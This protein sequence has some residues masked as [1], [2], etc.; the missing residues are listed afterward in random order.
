MLDLDTIKK[1]VNVDPYFTDDDLY[2]LELAQV[3][4]TIILDA[5]DREDISSV[6]DDEKDEL[7]GGLKQ[8]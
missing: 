7:K 1:H 8:A 6:Y 3:T 2:L 4:K 5:I